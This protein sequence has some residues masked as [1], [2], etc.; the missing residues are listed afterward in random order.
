MTDLVTHRE[1][2]DFLTNA[3]Y[4]RT[5]MAG[6]HRDSRCKFDPSMGSSD[7]LADNFQGSSCVLYVYHG[8][9][10]FIDQSC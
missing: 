7:T 9:H 5:S 4:I 1:K 2:T 10:L 3:M 6:T 8:H